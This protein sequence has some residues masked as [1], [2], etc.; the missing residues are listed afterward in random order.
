MSCPLKRDEDRFQFGNRYPIQFAE[1][2]L[3]S[4]SQFFDP[5]FASAVS[6]EVSLI[7]DEKLCRQIDEL[8]FL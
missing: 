1:E 6:K 5:R 2:L 3:T 7:A 4:I 8:G